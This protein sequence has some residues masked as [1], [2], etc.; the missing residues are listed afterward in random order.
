MAQHGFSGGIA[1]RFH[2][3]IEA[4]RDEP[5]FSCELGMALF[6]VLAERH[7]HGSLEIAARLVVFIDQVSDDL[8]IGLGVEGVALFAQAVF[9]IEVILNDP[10]VHHDETVDIVRMGIDLGRTAMGRPAGVT[11]TGLAD[12]GL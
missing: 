3:E 12:K 5:Q 8:R 7:A 11:D 2:A 6:Q 4:R 10:I 1:A 9:Q